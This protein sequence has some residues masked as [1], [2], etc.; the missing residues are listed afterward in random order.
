M[1]Q[2]TYCQKRTKE[3]ESK[4]TRINCA[5]F[6]YYSCKIKIKSRGLALCC[7]CHFL[8]KMLPYLILTSTLIIWSCCEVFTSPNYSIPVTA[9]GPLCPP[10]PPIKIGKRKKR[11][12]EFTAPTEHVLLLWRRVGMRP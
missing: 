6:I 3:S 10:R 4:G 1:Y 8:S 7:Y 5:S 2:Q 11:Q 9:G 12:N